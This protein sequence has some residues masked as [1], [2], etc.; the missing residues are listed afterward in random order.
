MKTTFQSMGATFHNLS[1]METRNLAM[2]EHNNK[3]LRDVHARNYRGDFRER[4]ASPFLLGPAQDFPIPSVAKVD[5]ANTSQLSRMGMRNPVIAA[6]GMEYERDSIEEYMQ[7]RLVKGLELR[8]PITNEV[9]PHTV[10]T[11]VR[12]YAPI[13]TSSRSSA[14]SNTVSPSA[15]SNLGL[16]VIPTTQGGLLSANV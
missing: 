15:T 11:P 2:H 7:H 12:Q 5:L 1:V 9:L 16:K 10:L 13:Q 14:L 8:S 4:E 6:D 3:L